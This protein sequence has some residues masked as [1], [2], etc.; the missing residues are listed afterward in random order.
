WDMDLSRWE[1][2]KTQEKHKAS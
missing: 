2:I 1:K